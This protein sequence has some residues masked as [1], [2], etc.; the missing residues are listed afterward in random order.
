MKLRPGG[1]RKKYGRLRLYDD[2][3]ELR[4][5]LKRWEIKATT[6]LPARAAVLP[7]ATVTKQKT[8]ATRVVAGTLVAGPIGTVVGAKSKKQKTQVQGFPVL[9]VWTAS[10]TVFY[11]RQALR[12]IHAHW[13]ARQ[14]NTQSRRI[15]PKTVPPAPPIAGR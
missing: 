8:T 9:T 11:H 3:I 15:E 4:G 12:L 10:G 1:P 14:I 2:H 7:A 5:R 6:P 13:V